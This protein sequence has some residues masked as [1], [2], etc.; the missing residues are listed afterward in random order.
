[1]KEGKLTEEQIAGAMVF[2]ADIFPQQADV[3]RL[4]KPG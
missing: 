3:K 4:V 1:M 2:I